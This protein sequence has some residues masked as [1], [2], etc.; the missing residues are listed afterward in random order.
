MLLLG[1]VGV[2]PFAVPEL[3]TGHHQLRRA[4]QP[5]QANKDRSLANPQPQTRREMIMEVFNKAQSLSGINQNAER[6]FSLLNDNSFNNFNSSYGLNKLRNS[7]GITFNNNDQ[8]NSSSNRN[9]GTNFSNQ[10]PKGE[11]TD[12]AVS[13]Q[14]SYSNYIKWNDLN[15]AYNRNVIDKIKASNVHHQIDE[16]QKDYKAKDKERETSIFDNGK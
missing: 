9:N 12:K 5:F 3:H 14:E 16:Q 4:A 1:V 7:S 11:L 2:S 8:N 6:K 10:I 13:S 15:S